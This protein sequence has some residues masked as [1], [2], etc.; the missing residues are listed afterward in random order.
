[1][2]FTPEEGRQGIIQRIWNNASI[3]IRFYL[4]DFAK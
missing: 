1:M 3:R 2:L 4:G